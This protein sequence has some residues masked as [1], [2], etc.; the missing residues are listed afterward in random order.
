MIAT[1][2]NTNP[3]QTH[4]K[5]SNVEAD[6]KMFMKEWKSRWW[7]AEGPWD[8]DLHDFKQLLQIFTVARIR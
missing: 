4:L 2:Q 5:T 8:L 7:I 6:K 3:I 1:E